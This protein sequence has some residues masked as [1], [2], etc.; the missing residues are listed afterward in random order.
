MRLELIDATDEYVN[1]MIE[2]LYPSL[3]SLARERL[4]EEMMNESSIVDTS[5]T[6]AI[7]NLESPKA[8]AAPYAG[9]AI[10]IQEMA[11]EMGRQFL[12]ERFQFRDVSQ[13]FDPGEQ[14]IRFGDIRPQIASLAF[15]RDEASR[16]IEDIPP[17]PQF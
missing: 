12:I 11:R 4:I 1:R 7:G 6:I 3:E 8:T 15:D 17:A 14:V 5:V 9:L 10:R 13:E 2:L 16:F